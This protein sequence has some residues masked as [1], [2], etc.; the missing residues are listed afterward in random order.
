M[1]Q[2]VKWEGAEADSS[3]HL[4]ESLALLCT[5]ISWE[6]SECAASQ[7][8]FS[9]TRISYTWGADQE[10]AHVLSIPGDFGAGV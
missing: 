4:W 2:V 6:L 10:S 8:L 9:E 7:T 3:Q 1:S 5:H